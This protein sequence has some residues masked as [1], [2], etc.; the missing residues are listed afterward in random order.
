MALTDIQT[1]QCTRFLDELYRWNER[2]NLTSID[3]T[4]AWARHVQESCD[5]AEAVPTGTKTIVDVGSGGGI[6]GIVLAVLFPD[7]DVVLVE[8]DQRK[9]GF[10]MHVAGLLRLNNVEVL[11]RRAEIMGRDDAY[12]EHFDVAVSRAAGPLERV[13]A[14][15]LDLVRPGGL[16]LLALSDGQDIAPALDTIREHGG[17]DVQRLSSL[18]RI[19][20]G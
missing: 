18:L 20:K 11:A 17:N 12:G 5:F 7:V 10:L 9:C 1:Q 3:R 8:V 6:P 2:I 16:A 4:D 15:T 14:W 13:V 19:T